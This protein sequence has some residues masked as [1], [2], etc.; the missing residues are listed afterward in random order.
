MLNNFGLPGGGSQDF[1]CV[2]QFCQ[3]YKSACSLVSQNCEIIMRNKKLK[4]LTTN[5]N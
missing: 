4:K 3:K 5:E 2:I 1:N